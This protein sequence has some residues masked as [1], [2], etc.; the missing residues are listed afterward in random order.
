MFNQNNHATIQVVATNT[1][2]NLPWTAETWQ[3]IPHWIPSHSW[4]QILEYMRPITTATKEARLLTSP[5]GA[6]GPGP[7]I[8]PFPRGLITGQKPTASHLRQGEA[9]HTEIKTMSSVSTGASC[10]FRDG[11]L[12]TALPPSRGKPLTARES[13]AKT[14]FL[15][16]RTRSN[17]LTLIDRIPHFR[18]LGAAAEVPVLACPV[19]ARILRKPRKFLGR[20]GWLSGP[21]SRVGAGV[22]R[23]TSAVGLPLVT[24]A[25]CGTGVL[26]PFALGV[27]VFDSSARPCF[28]LSPHLR[29]SR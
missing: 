2:W 26:F 16:F 11:S 24:S 4:R 18:F 20:M 14:T 10:S 12:S 9:V 25:S 5:F 29:P 27:C 22:P 19:V 3:W 23:P 1:K 21:T 8:L 15:D 13:E 28:C 7:N 17:T 6:Q